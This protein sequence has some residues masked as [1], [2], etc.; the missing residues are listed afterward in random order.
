[1]FFDVVSPLMLGEQMS[2]NKPKQLEQKDMMYCKCFHCKSGIIWHV[3]PWN[4]R[5]LDIATATWQA[6]VISISLRALRGLIEAVVNKYHKA[7][8]K[9][10]IDQHAI[11][12]VGSK[13]DYHGLT[14]SDLSDLPTLENV[15]I[16]EDCKATAMNR[17]R[18][19]NEKKRS[20]MTW[21][22][23]QKYV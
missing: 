19:E 21:P 13:W 10:K 3:H 22:S 20:A 4:L 14:M 1:M 15:W 16:E 9:R 17:L 8:G 6:S 18:T 12:V 2:T 23:C 11:P 5:K 7:D